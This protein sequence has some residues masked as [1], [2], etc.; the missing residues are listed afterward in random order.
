[1]ASV[2]VKLGFLLLPATL[3]FAVYVIDT[4]SDDT[5]YYFSETHIKVNLDTYSKACNQLPWDAGPV[6]VWNEADQLFLFESYSG[7]NSYL[8]GHVGPT[9]DGGF[10]SYFDDKTYYSNFENESA[11]R[12]GNLGIAYIDFPHNWWKVAPLMGPQR[13]RYICHMANPCTG[14]LGNPCG[15]SALCVFN[16]SSGLFYC[17]TNATR[18]E[19]DVVCLNYGE[20][21]DQTDGYL[22]QCLQYYTGK[23]CEYNIGCQ[24][25]NPC[26][27]GGTCY[28]R[29]FFG[30]PSCQC[31]DD[32]RGFRCEHDDFSNCF[33]GHDSCGRFQC[34]ASQGWHSCLCP[35][36]TD[37]NLQLCVSSEL[38][39]MCLEENNGYRYLTWTAELVNQLSKFVRPYVNINGSMACGCDDVMD[40]N[41]EIDVNECASSPCQN[42][43][44]CVD[45][46]DGYTCDCEYTDDPGY[47]GDQCQYRRGKCDLELCQHGGTC[48][49][50]YLTS[51][52]W[53]EI[54]NCTPTGYT[55]GYCHIEV[56]ECKSSPCLHNGRCVDQIN[57]YNCNC[58]G[59]GYVGTRCD[60]NVEHCPK[61][62]TGQPGAR[63]INE[64][65][66]S[67]C[68]HGSCLDELLEYR[69]D[70]SDTGYDGTACDI[71]IDEC[72][73]NPCNE[74]NCADGVNYF[75]CICF[76]G[77]GGERCDVN[78]GNT[79]A[80][81][82]KSERKHFI[83][84]VVA[85]VLL[86]V[87]FV[88]VVALCVFRH[89]HKI[90][91]RSS[92]GHQQPT[93]Y[94]EIS[95]EERLVAEVST[96][97]CRCLLGG[98]RAVEAS[99][100]FAV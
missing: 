84:Y 39:T 51:I 55:G 80:S 54:C 2:V 17:Q 36:P 95:L 12:S 60:I 40:D 61:D 22:C 18:C 94:V 69:C 82:E 41:C 16:A 71:D 24:I 44:L 23:H 28:N 59:T 57:A 3:S 90:S 1:M 34:I 88:A 62:G 13:M 70:C 76:A 5:I 30:G 79:T 8:I 46:H 25:A 75:M 64:C 68:R 10:S 81:Q 93:G 92:Q 6:I 21:I 52:G 4:T 56:D 97:A 87:C 100:N 35:H 15:R 45:K 33:R 20:C 29:Q 89:R 67:P 14:I 98:V 53:V 26:Q 77:Y 91:I 99:T 86:L 48:E 38:S 58:S 43:G 11:A 74:G 63:N 50:D 96:L 9:K 32:Y 49:R 42:N 66:S 85:G 78:I 31:T 7:N 27:N 73:S 72:A 37:M 19:D 83:S 47:V 65:G